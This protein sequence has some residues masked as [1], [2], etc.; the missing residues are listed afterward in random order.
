LNLDGA[1]NAAAARSVLAVQ[2][3][4]AGGESPLWTDDDRRWATRLA[5]E[6]GANKL[7]AAAALAA[8]AQHALQRLLP[9]QPALQRVLQAA[10][11]LPAWAIAVPLLALVAGVA[12]DAVGGTQRINLLAPPVWAVITWNLL[13][14]VAL[15]LPRGAWPR[16]LRA[17]LVARSIIGARGGAQGGTAPLQAFAAAWARVAS[18]AVAS[19]V[20]LL[21]HIGAAALALG[22]I[23][24]LYLRGLVLDY[25]VAWQSTFLD[26]ASVHAVLA[27]LL[28]PASALT[29]IAVPD[30]AAI[31][32]LQ[33]G[34]GADA[35]AASAAPWIHLYAAMLG[36]CVLLPRMLLAA[37][38]GW[39]AHRLS[40]QVRLPLHE[41]YFQRLLRELQGSAADV[42][43]L[44]QGAAPTAQ[45]T[46]GL[47]D[48]LSAA[49]GEG[50]QLRIAEPVPYGSEDAAMTLQALQASASTSLRVLLVD[51]ASTPDDDSHGRLLR[52][53]RAQQPAAPWLVLADE[54]GFRR[55]FASMP[56]RLAERRAA[57]QAWARAQGAGWVGVDLDGPALTTAEADLQQALRGVTA[58]TTS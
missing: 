3:F 28:A 36:L 48:W 49:C 53:L 15:L 38:A 42:Q 44:P 6:S 27:A 35:A 41:P 21:L 37:A 7:P 34:P 2:A 57:W 30:T 52:A 40:Q 20:A 18:P 58:A 9:R 14:Y 50:L 13:V 47:R 22:L 16:P 25:R 39:R 12:V 1:L 43:V 54:A 29:G 26:A 17:A 32:A 23:A 11:R 51:L 31:A 5:R 8:R 46:L 56:A 55:R 24:G 4:E 33:T 19:R 10:D 45:A